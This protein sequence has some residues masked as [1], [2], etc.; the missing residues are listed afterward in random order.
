MDRRRFIGT[1]AGGLLAGPHIADGQ[2]AGRLPVVGVLVTDIS[3]NLSLPI[4]L[5]GLR[6]L[7][8]V[9]GKNIEIAVRS[10]GGTPDVFPARAAEL[11]QLKVDVIFA[12]GP[13]ATRAAKAAT[14]VIPIVAIDRETDPV[15]AG[16]AR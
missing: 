1:V 8:Y 4:L 13:A 9:D 16:W 12:T 6:D 14:T 10:A 5:Q 15:Q 3:G 7:D 11:V 2:T